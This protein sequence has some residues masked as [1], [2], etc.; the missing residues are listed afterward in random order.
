MIVDAEWDARRAN[1]RTRLLRGARFPAPD[2]N[3]DDVRYDAD[4]K[5]DRGRIMELSNCGW[6]KDRRN[7][8]IT[9]ASGAGRTWLACALGV[10]VCNSFYSVRYVRLPEMVDE[11][12]VGRDEEWL[13]TKRK[14]V[15]CGLL[16]IDDW[17]LEDV[18][19]K[20]AREILEIVEGRQRTGSLLLCS[21]FSATGWHARLGEGAIAD[22]VIDRIVYS[23]HVIHIEGTESMRKRI[24]ALP[25]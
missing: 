10:A 3:V 11:L 25:K 9:G 1:K 19:A 15:C 20:G 7:V 5:L 18:K 23:S 12:A 17:L 24:G 4:R 16:I 22:A 8:V 2:A 21:Q 13:K 6:I 14:Y